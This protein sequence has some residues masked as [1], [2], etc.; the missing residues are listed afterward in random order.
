MIDVFL[1]AFVA[2][3]G[4]FSVAVSSVFAV[5]GLISNS[6][7]LT[8]L[9]SFLGTSLGT[10]ELQVL[11]TL[12]F[13]LF[14][15]FGSKFIKGLLYGTWIV[16]IL[17]ILLMWYILGATSNATFVQHWDTLF[18]SLNSTYTYSSLQST[19]VTKGA[20]PGMTSGFAGIIL[21]LPL[22]FLFLF[23]GN[24]AN[25]FA[26]EIK[27]V[28]R[29]LPI[30][31]FLSLLFGVVYWSITSQLTISTVG[32][33]WLTQVGYAWLP[34]SCA[35]SASTPAY[36]LPFQLTQPLFLAVAAY[37]NS[38]LITVMFITYL[39]GSLGA[40]FAY[41]WVPSKY[42]FAWSFDRVIPSKFADVNQR[43]HTPY[44]S[45]IAIVVIGVILSFLYSILGYSTLFTMGSLVW[46][47]S[48]IVPGLALTVFPYVKKD[49][50]SQAPGWVAKKVAGIPVVSIVG[51]LTVIGF[52]YVGYVGYSN[53]AFA[54]PN[55]FGYELYTSLIIV[56]FLIYFASRAYHKSRGLD[57]SQALK[58]IPPE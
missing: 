24:Y 3:I 56:G 13:G 11:F 40:L 25:G 22:A 49:L 1:V 47:V 15:I 35:G 31:L 26:G 10:F 23:G 5:Y 6:A 2:E 8:N 30:A 43:F 7:Y 20:F 4:P 18:G 14:A 29:S 28:K 53:A 9:G 46:G 45:V 27:N 42:M 36:P 32:L 33:N 38:S 17:G 52:G 12:V 51:V 16:A 41:F 54:V 34:C 58:E 21:A 48:Y 37:P 55:A 19:A 39:V 50:F 44:L 57:I